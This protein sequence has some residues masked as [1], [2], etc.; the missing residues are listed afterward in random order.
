MASVQA[1]DAK[2]SEVTNQT[3]ET[4]KECCGGCDKKL[5]TTEA[6]STPTTESEK[7]EPKEVVL[8]DDE[9]YKLAEEEHE[10]DNKAA[11]F[12]TDDEDLKLTDDIEHEGH[13]EEDDEID[14]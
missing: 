3:E 5:P 13:V 9:D 6:V 10:E 4:K 14:D 7:A 8:T 2:V 12:P 1:D 11:M